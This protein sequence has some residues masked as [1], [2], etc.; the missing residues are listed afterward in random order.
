[1]RLCELSVS[2]FSVYFTVL[3][4]CNGN[5]DLPNFNQNFMYSANTPV[6]NGRQGIVGDSEQVCVLLRIHN[7]RAVFGGPGTL[8]VINVTCVTYSSILDRFIYVIKTSYPKVWSQCLM[9]DYISGK[10]STRMNSYQCMP[11]SSQG[12]LGFNLALHRRSF[13]L[14]ILSII[15]KLFYLTLRL[16]FEWCEAPTTGI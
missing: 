6:H 9:G 15:S 13:I 2:R 1:M 8:P 12:A 7:F 4:H 11:T 14:H 5:L 10:L 3:L 16:S